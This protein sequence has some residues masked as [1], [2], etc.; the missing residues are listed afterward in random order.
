VNNLTATI[1]RLGIVK[2]QQAALRREEE[3][4]KAV[5]IEQGPGAY[6]GEL[7]RATVS[8]SEQATL[9]MDA[10]RAKLSAQFIAAHTKITPVTAV[11]VVARI[12]KLKVRAS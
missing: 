2:S 12:G 9:D 10:V 5:L 6:E 4:L 11:R 8:H 7:Y 3:Q 1:D